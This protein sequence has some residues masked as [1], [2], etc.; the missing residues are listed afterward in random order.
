MSHRPVTLWAGIPVLVLTLT[1]VAWT[2]VPSGAAAP[3]TAEITSTSFRPVGSGDLPTGAPALQAPHAPLTALERGYAIHLA[4]QAQPENTT[5]VL[6]NPGGEVLSAEL[7]PMS[8]RS[9]H[10]TA[11]VTL[12]DYTDNKL[13]QVQVNLT[14]AR[15]VT[16]EL[17]G[18]QLPP[19]AA[20]TRVATQIAIA[21]TTELNFMAQYRTMTGTPL[22][23]PEQVHTVAGVW[24]AP[25]DAGSPSAVCGVNRCVQ[26]LLGL[27]SG[28]YLNTQDFVVDLTTRSVLPLGLTETV[29]EH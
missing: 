13:A 25:H 22:L 14:S 15:A 18:V 4:Q 9:A 26:L 29:H 3:G 1:A 20:E 19:S 5:S 17:A 10:R 2:L 12:Y 16:T 27:P 8:E 28:Q 23:T 11:V 24:R 21:S 6:G 7:P